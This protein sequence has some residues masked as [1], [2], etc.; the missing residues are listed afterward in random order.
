M[1]DADV[2]LVVRWPD[3]RDAPFLPGKV[4]EYLSHRKPILIVNSVAGGEAEKLVCRIGAGRCCSDASEIHEVL[5][6]WM[7]Q[8]QRDGRVTVTYD[9]SAMLGLSTLEFGRQYEEL[10]ARTVSR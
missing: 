5:S 1:D 9:D 10:L 6:Y 7:A 4:L 8:K 2:L 3:Q